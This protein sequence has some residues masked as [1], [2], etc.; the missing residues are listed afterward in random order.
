MSETNDPLDLDARL[1]ESVDI[2]TRLIN[3][4]AADID[5]VSKDKD[6]STVLLKALKDNDSA[7]LGKARQKVEENNS[8][9]DRNIGAGV[10]D[11]IKGLQGKDPYA[12]ENS[13]SENIP[14]RPN[15]VDSEF[16]I[17]DTVLSE[18]GTQ[19]TIDEFNKRMLSEGNS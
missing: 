17:P 19:E 12:V 6:L 1:T 13:S 11:F 16:D 10:L 3:V 5:G 7:V 9:N 2:R 4:L 15:N 14:S 18:G 8:D